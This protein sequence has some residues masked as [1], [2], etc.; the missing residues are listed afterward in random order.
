MVL[1]SV[2]PDSIGVATLRA[3]VRAVEPE[4]PVPFVHARTTA[5][6]TVVDA[7]VKLTEVKATPDFVE[8]GYNATSLSMHVA[9]I[10]NWRM[11]G[12]AAVT[13]RAPNGTTVFTRSV[14]LAIA[15]NDADNTFDLGAIDTASFASGIYTAEVELAIHEPAALAE[16]G[17]TTGYGLL[18][19]GQGI[20]AAIDVSPAIVVPGDAVVTT[21]ITTERTAFGSGAGGL[22][23]DSTPIAARTLQLLAPANVSNNN[24]NAGVPLHLEATCGSTRI[25]VSSTTLSAQPRLSGT[26]SMP[27][28]TVLTVP[29]SSRGFPP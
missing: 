1:W 23:I 17:G 7:L 28:L 16:L 11:R 9:N 13:I 14:P 4:G 26:T 6:L 5:G 2:T 20:S 8:T 12:Q 22:P 15:L 24:P 25:P 29:S 3:D 21:T 10:A 18:S 19:V 27:R